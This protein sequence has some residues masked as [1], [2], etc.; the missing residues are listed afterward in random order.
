[1]CV[2]VC[3]LYDLYLS[4]QARNLEFSACNVLLF[5]EIE[6]KYPLTWMVRFSPMFAGNFEESHEFSPLLREFNVDI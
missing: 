3:V 4:Q 5:G 2:C 1:M 6:T